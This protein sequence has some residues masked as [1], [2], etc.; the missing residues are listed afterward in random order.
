MLKFDIKQAH[1]MV[2][3]QR[4]AGN[5]VRWDNYDIVFFRPAEVAMYSPDGAFRDGKWGYENRFAVNEQGIWEVDA[6]NIRRVRSART[7]PR[8]T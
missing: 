1:R 4:S 8:R 3:Q 2:N 5:D 7:R 6:R